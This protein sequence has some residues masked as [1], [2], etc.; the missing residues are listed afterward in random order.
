MKEGRDNYRLKPIG[1][2]IP[3][4]NAVKKK[5]NCERKRIYIYIYIVYIYIYIYIYIYYNRVGCHHLS[6]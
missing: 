2:K 5:Q 4:I 3:L 6:S 1:K